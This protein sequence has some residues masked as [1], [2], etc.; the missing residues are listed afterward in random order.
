MNNEFTVEEL[1]FLNT[2]AAGIPIARMYSALGWSASRVDRVRKSVA[3]KLQAGM[4]ASP[5]ARGGSSISTV[6]RERIN[7]GAWIWQPAPVVTSQA[8]IEEI[9]K[10]RSRSIRISVLPGNSINKRILLSVEKQTKTLTFDL[11]ARL[12]DARRT[13]E[14]IWGQRTA[15]E[16]SLRRVE[17]E[18]D[19]AKKAAAKA[20]EDAVLANTTESPKFAAKIIELEAECEEAGRHQLAVDGAYLRAR[21]AVETIEAEIDARRTEA[22]LA[23]AT[24]EA[25]EVMQALLTLTAAIGRLTATTNR[26]RQ[27]AYAMTELLLPFER[28]V[29]DYR[30]IA[31]NALSAAL[32]LHQFE[33]Q[34][35]GLCG[36][37]TERDP[38][39]RIAGAAD[40]AAL[41][42]LVT[43]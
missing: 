7:G 15:S 25:A 10:S 8:F 26:H 16:E 11:D 3:A 22:Y 18:L 34:S 20:A 27:S 23:D 13:A 43:A 2:K 29:T 40:A 9:L 28:C 12:A 39:G 17:S 41:R 37:E 21:E 14:R 32:A 36:T 1:A 19:T 33:L 42:R 5:I 24:P 30:Q 4:T 38:T 31:C 35:P 6:F